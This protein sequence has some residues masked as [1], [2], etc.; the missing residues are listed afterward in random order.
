MKRKSMKRKVIADLIAIVVIVSAV[1]FSGCIGGFRAPETHYTVTATVAE[2]IVG[3]TPTI[4]VTYTGGPDAAQVDAI[5][6]VVDGV[7]LTPPTGWG[8]VDN[9]NSDVVVGTTQSTTGT[10]E[11]YDNHVIVTATFID[12]TTQVI[13]DTYV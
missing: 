6:A 4:N 9:S 7:A 13:V 11:K 12:G 3:T 2:Q 5:T 10:A 1:A 8:S